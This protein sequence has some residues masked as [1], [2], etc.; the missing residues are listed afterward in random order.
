MAASHATAVTSPD[1]SAV[2]SRARTAQQQW[3]NTALSERLRIIRKIRNGIAAEGLT[4]C[5]LFPAELSRTRAHS[6]VTE[7]IPLADACR[8]LERE[9]NQILAP[10]CLS[11]NSRPFWSRAVDIQLRRDPVGIVLIIGPSNYPLFLP[12][13]QALQ[14]LVAGNAVILKPG[15]GGR[16]VA[17][18]L[19]SFA[20]SAGVPNDLFVVL[21]ES[22]Q[23]AQRII[24][25]GIDMVVLTGSLETGRAVYRQAA[26][27]LIPAVLELSGCDPVFIQPGA[28]LKRAVD[29]I[30]FGC[31][32]NGGN[33]CI[34]PRRIFVIESLADEFER[35]LRERHAQTRFPL[36]ITRVSN[37]DEALELAAASPYALGAAVFG[38]HVSAKA[39][40]AKVVAGVVVVNDMIAPTAD[41]RVP[42]GGRRS[43]GFG[44]TRGAEGLLQLTALKAVVA[45]KRK[46]LRHL[47]PLPHNTQEIFAAY[48]AAANKISWRER[49]I[50]SCHLLT[51]LARA[52]RDNT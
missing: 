22:V 39:F 30:A 28:D 10:R 3:A 40:A 33:T 29:A 51:A 11:T 1:T 17:D 27:E 5:D 36:S 8:F 16:N 50:A 9:A 38:E 13:V 37:D 43:S 18:A 41:P 31:H 4:L 52:K 47:E 34:A 23:S 14:A 19:H 24:G 7:V 46:R 44:A 15:R 21:D 25:G 45:Q 2:I 20:V 12:G 42:F 26:G 49:L 48:L 6:L 35:I 32:W